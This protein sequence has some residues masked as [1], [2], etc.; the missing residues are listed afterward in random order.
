MSA[1][2]IRKMDNTTDRYI[3]PA[4]EAAGYQ[5]PGFNPAE[6]L[7]WPNSPSLMMAECGY[8]LQSPDNDGS[9]ANAIKMSSWTLYL[10]ESQAG[11]SFSNL[12]TPPDSLPIPF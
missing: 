6:L 2:Q 1:N 7:A 5:C 9:V 12:W 4:D 3:L 10:D 8:W 11:R